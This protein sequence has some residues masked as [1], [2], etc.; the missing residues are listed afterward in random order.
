MRGLLVFFVLLFSKRDS[1]CVRA[2]L[3]V[4]CLLRCWF[5]EL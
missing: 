4:R 1:F 2:V 5:V 3:C